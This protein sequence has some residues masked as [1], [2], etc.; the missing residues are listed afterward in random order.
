MSPLT[1]GQ[2]Q[3]PYLPAFQGIPGGGVGGGVGIDALGQYF[4]LISSE[5]ARRQA[6]A[7]QER[8]WRELMAS[9][10]RLQNPV[11]YS[12]PSG[13]DWGSAGGYWW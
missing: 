2:V 4:N 6:A 8:M 1:P 12:L 5:R 11:G 3:L 7:D 13:Y 9:L 10:N